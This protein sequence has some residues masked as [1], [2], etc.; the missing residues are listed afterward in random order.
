[1]LPPPAA[2][3]YNAPMLVFAIRNLRS[4]PLRTI[5]ALCGLTVAIAG[6]VALF[7]IAEGIEAS[8]SA[9]F[10]K[11]PGLAVMQPGAPIPLL[12]RIPAEW[13]E[14]I[15]R[16]PGVHVVHS[17]VWS[18][19]NMIEGAPSL[20][21]PRFLFGSDLVQADRLYYSVYRANMR[22][23]RPLNAR[24]SG[25]G[26][27]VI[28]QPIAEQFHKGLGDV[29]RV[30]GMNL[31]IVGIY[32]CNSL[33]LDVSIITDIARVREVAR[34]GPESVS[35]F[36]VEPEKGAD[37]AAL[38][39]NIKALFR[40]R[41]PAPRASALPLGLSGFN[42]AKP[43]AP[44]PLDRPEAEPQPSLPDEL[45]VEVRSP[46]DWAEQFRKFSA[47]LDLFLLVMTCVGVAIAFVGIVN[48]MLMSVSERM[49]EFGI[50]KANGWASSDVLRL[51]GLES[52]VLGL[53][54]GVVGS[55]IGWL[56]TLLVNAQ[57][58]TRIALY[59]SPKLL[60]MSLLFSTALGILAGLY[61]AVRAA[62]MLPMDAIRRG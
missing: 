23:G 45:P 38:A 42:L 19:A 60:V 40:G 35:N 55:T 17:E 10:A 14:E 29:L 50:L 15:S 41:G 31:V 46:D 49:I 12:S 57:W 16:V 47:D 44:E 24:D 6:M 39:Q 26:N 51:I 7:S 32:R 5:L 11:I 4:R 53:I 27:C 36:Y 58:P 37:R 33:F 20:T 25:T 62:R 52:A 34:M 30:D 54:G 13:G 59:A 9:T 56:V 43:Q 18:R 2:S 48:T 22:E 21:P 61:P 8:V 3:R 1:M 28:A